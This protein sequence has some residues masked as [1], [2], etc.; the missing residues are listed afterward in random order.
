[1]RTQI[2]H[3]RAVYVHAIIISF[4]KISVHVS[5]GDVGYYDNDGHMIISDRIKEMIKVKGHQVQHIQ[6]IYYRLL[7]LA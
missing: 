3:N 6:N 2:S 5:L 7:L 4:T 1:M